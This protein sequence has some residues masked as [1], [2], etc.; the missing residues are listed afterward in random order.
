MP[1]GE[2]LN[3]VTFA[4][5]GGRTTLT[6]LV[7]CGSQGYSRLLS[8][9]AGGRHAGG[10]DLLEQITIELSGGL[11]VEPREHLG[12]HVVRGGCRRCRRPRRGGGRAGACRPV[13][14]QPLRRSRPRGR[15]RPRANGN[16]TTSSSGTSRC[17]TA[18]KSMP[19]SANSAREPVQHVP[20]AAGERGPRLV[21]QLVGRRPAAAMSPAPRPSGVPAAT[22][23]RSSSPEGCSTPSARASRSPCVPFPLPGGPSTSALHPASLRPNVFTKALA[24]WPPPVPSP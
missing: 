24:R 14:A 2:V 6:I 15:P 17:T 7:D 10:M 4:D 21:D 8:P 12:E 22:A 5:A 23:S 20:V 18:S 1:D 9:P 19:A 11:R 13:L 3:T 16:R